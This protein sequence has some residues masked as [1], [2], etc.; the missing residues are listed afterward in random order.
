MRTY[1]FERDERGMPTRMIWTGDVPARPNVAYTVC[2]RCRSRR[3]EANNCFNCWW[4][5]PLTWDEMKVRVDAG[6]KF[7]RVAEKGRQP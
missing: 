3:M 4:R 7:Y 2:P 1:H 5:A 6:E